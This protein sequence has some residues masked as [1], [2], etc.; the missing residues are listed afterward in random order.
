MEQ[1][2]LIDSN[3][4][5]SNNKFGI[6]IEVLLLPMVTDDKFWLFDDNNEDDDIEEDDDHWWYSNESYTGWDYKKDLGEDAWKKLKTGK[7]I[8]I[9]SFSG[10]LLCAFPIYLNKQKMVYLSHFLDLNHLV[11]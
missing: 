6:D 1:N 7:P 9:S 8:N 11:Y 3:L 5:D 10:Y 4:S 2:L